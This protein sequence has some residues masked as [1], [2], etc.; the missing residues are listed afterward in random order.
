MSAIGLILNWIEDPWGSV[1]L[2]KHRK[3]LIKLR[4]PRDSFITISWMRVHLS[5]SADVNC[6]LLNSIWT[7]RTS[8]I[9]DNKHH[10]PAPCCFEFFL[11]DPFEVFV[12]R[13]GLEY[14]LAF[15]IYFYK[16]FKKITSLFFHTLLIQKVSNLWCLFY[17]NHLS[18]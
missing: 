1:T 9:S 3:K 16:N 11:R 12:L 18:F 13:I 17:N 6:L 2:Y 7:P 5:R 10:V 15:L 14:F 8:P 4:T